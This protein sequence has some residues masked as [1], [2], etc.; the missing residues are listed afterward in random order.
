MADDKGA[1]RNVDGER[2][3]APGAPN[4]PPAAVPPPPPPRTAIQTTIP[5]SLSSAPTTVPVG[6][7]PALVGVG[8][9]GPAAG[10]GIQPVGQTADIA[11][12][13]GLQGLVQSNAAMG[14]A[15]K[16][17]VGEMKVITERTAR[18]Q[19]STASG[20]GVGSPDVAAAV[21]RA[22]G[23][24]SR[25][26]MMSS[27]RFGSMAFSPAM[28]TAGAGSG[29]MP[30]NPYM[31]G[32]RGTFP[33]TEQAE[34]MHQRTGPGGPTLGVPHLGGGGGGVVA[35]GG[36]GWGD[37]GGGE[38]PEH[39]YRRSPA[40]SGD[41]SPTENMSHPEVPEGRDPDIAKR[42]W[43]RLQRARGYSLGDLRQ[44]VG[45]A[46]AKKLSEWNWQGGL[47]EVSL[48]TM[49]GGSVPVGMAKHGSHALATAEEFAQR[50]A[51]AGGIKGAASQ[52]GAGEGLGKLATGMLPEG[53]GMALGGVVGGAV[54]VQQGLKFAEQQ[55]KANAGWQEIM[56]GSN[57]EGMTQRMH[58]RAFA[59]SQ[60]GTMGGGDAQRLYEES[61]RLGYRGENLQNALGNATEWYRKFGMSVEE[62]SKLLEIAARTGQTSLTGFT[63]ALTD[64]TKAARTAG[65]SAQEMRAKFT[66]GLESVSTMA[67]PGQAPVMAA[68]QVVAQTQYGGELARNLDFSGQN[69]QTQI[70]MQARMAG[71]TP[72]QYVGMMSRPGG[73]AKVAANR[74]TMLRQRSGQL[75]GAPGG[76]VINQALA[77]RGISMDDIR[78]GKVKMKPGEIQQMVDQ[79]MQDPRTGASAMILPQI[80]ESQMGISGTTPRTA[81]EMLMKSELGVGSQ[82]AAVRDKAAEGQTHHID[83]IQKTG[84]KTSGITSGT[85]KAYQDLTSRVQGGQN[86]PNASIVD[87]YT[88]GV[89]KTGR[90]GGI[91]EKIAT[92]GAKGK[93]TRVKVETAKGPRVVTLSDAMRYYRDQLDAGT[94]EV[95]AGDNVGQTIAEAMGTEGDSHVNVTSATST[96]IKSHGSSEKDFA[97]S[98][99]GD[100]GKI[101]VVASPELQKLLS[102]RTSGNVTSDSRLQPPNSRPT[103]DQL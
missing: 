76:Q 74:D 92:G 24:A 18:F 6:A 1:Y 73:A 42:N 59:F 50:E 2:H 12:M 15:V 30:I 28:L 41:V 75:L 100:A 9:A 72:N 49:S 29:T 64:V 4:P 43:Q 80:L 20:T 66:A 56:G 3:D 11:M 81:V 68:A 5:A 90:A 52:L 84:D 60:M 96:K 54:L 63:Q 16:D 23:S 89:L 32:M 38:R 71:M 17:A 39:P 31:P 47:H 27:L 46:A 95:M 21:E 69:S 34:R 70:F 45:K 37:G 8:A 58:S 62:S 93:A 77:Q 103:Q 40:S 97:A 98:G 48:P 83:T 91:S 19:G 26:M 102:F 79:Y 35:G 78:S 82:A 101:T 44:D 33:A 87:A 85:T 55:R 88:A 13:R 53:A 14:Q 65:L 61:N 57:W 36:G 10:A 7:P 94:A 99:K 25:D 51:L 86:R 22:M 67:G